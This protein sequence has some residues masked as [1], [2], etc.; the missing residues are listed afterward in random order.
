MADRKI[1]V[2]SRVIW[3]EYQKQGIWAEHYAKVLRHGWDR[4]G[5]YTEIAVEGVVPEEEGQVTTRVH[6]SSLHQIKES[7]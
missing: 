3:R 1:P 2:G 4:D 7:A 6:R 5:Q